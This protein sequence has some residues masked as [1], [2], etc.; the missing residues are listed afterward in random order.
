[1]DEDHQQEFNQRRIAVHLKPEAERAIRAG[2]PWIFEDSIIKQSHDG[3]AGDLAVVFDRKNRFL[4]IGLYDPHSS[5]RVRVLQYRNQAIIDEKW[6][7]E[8][9][10]KALNIRSELAS[11]RTNGF[12]LVHGENDGFPG[13]IVDRYDRNIVLKLYSA[14]W[15]QHLS[16]L[17]RLLLQHFSPE[18]I[19][20][21][22][23]RAVERVLETS[24]TVSDGQILHGPPLQGPIHFKENGLFFEVDPIQGHKTGFYLDQRDNRARVQEIIAELGGIDRLLDVFAYTGAFSIYSARAGAR[25][26]VSL[27]ISQ[28][29][30]STAQRSFRENGH[31][32][33]IAKAKHSCIAGDAFEELR[34]LSQKKQRFDAVIVD[35]PA[36]ANKKAQQRAAISAYSRLV[37]LTLKVLR[38][39]GLLVMSSCSSQIHE[40]QFYDCVIDSAE[41]AGRHLVEIA[42]TGHPKDHPISFPQGA[43]LKCLFATVL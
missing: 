13:L 40:S 29:A 36:F 23:S 4:A 11:D 41:K 1:M 42:R 39:G 10:T 3:Q 34:K 16:M 25:E 20:L 14:A 27:D 9:L 21:R 6:F 35:P 24:Q 30:L 33:N 18:R 15:A 28:P 22:L 2:H 17:V 43:Y 32:A 12:R 8:R 26:V 31:I 5:I 7:G 19:L 37:N 38:P